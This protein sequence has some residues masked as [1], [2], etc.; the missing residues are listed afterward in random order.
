MQTYAQT[1]AQKDKRDARRE[2]IEQHAHDPEFIAAF[3]ERMAKRD[4]EVAKLSDQAIAGRLR[5]MAR[6]VG[7]PMSR[8]EEEKAWA[9]S[10]RWIERSKVVSDEALEKWADR[11]RDTHSEAYCSG[12]CIPLSID[13]DCGDGPLIGSKSISLAGGCGAPYH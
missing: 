8:E 6:R 10:A 11:Y 2:E 1:E 12:P 9:S 3:R 4:P 5:D 13:S 7:K